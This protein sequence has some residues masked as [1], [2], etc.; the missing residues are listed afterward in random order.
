VL[1]CATNKLVEI[2]EHVFLQTRYPSCHPTNIIKALKRTPSTDANPGKITLCT[3]SLLDPP[4]ESGWKDTVPCM[5]A[6]LR[7]SSSG[8]SSAGCCRSYERAPGLMILQYPPYSQYKLR[9]Y[10]MLQKKLDPMLFHHVFAS[11]A[12]NCMKTF[13]ST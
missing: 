10:T 2:F 11:A 6:V 7:Q 9:K 3:L 12:I 4:A 8:L 5:L 13:R 1:A